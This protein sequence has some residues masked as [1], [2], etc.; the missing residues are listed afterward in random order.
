MQPIEKLEPENVYPEMTAAEAMVFVNE[1]LYVIE[2]RY[3]SS[4]ER[5]LLEG[6]WQGQ[7]YQDIAKSSKYATDYFKRDAGPKF[8][9]TILRIFN[10]GGSI[11]RTTVKK[12]IQ[13]QAYNQRAKI[14]NATEELKIYREKRTAQYF[15]EN[16]GEDIGIDMI[17]IPGGTFLMGSPEDELERS[18]TEGPQHEVTVNQFFMGRYPITQAQWQALAARS[19]V[20]RKLNIEPAAFKGDNRPVEQVSWQDAIE[21]CDRLT[22]YTGRPYRLPTEAEWEY[23]CRAGKTTPF[24]FGQSITTEL[25]NY[26]GSITYANSPQ[27]EYREETTPVDYFG[28]ANAFGLCDMH[29][30]VYEWCQDHWHENYQG[31]SDNGNVWLTSDPKTNRVIRGGAWLY[32]PKH[33][34]SA[35]RYTYPPDSRL[36]DTGFRIVCAIPTSNG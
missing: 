4:L 26:K 18:E 7:G 6:I 12:F 30:N 22:R 15:T 20:N 35:S 14:D 19:Q 21:F 23:A 2:Q 13:Q 36:Y 1:R 9:K 11:S 31:A 17:L 34:R 10:S 16:V 5:T 29:G 25:I 8:L 27:G 24:Y 28:V 3:L 32:E 33:C